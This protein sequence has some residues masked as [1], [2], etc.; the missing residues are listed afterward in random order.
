M[1]LFVLQ[2]EDIWRD[3]TNEDYMCL[4]PEQQY[5]Q[6]KSHQAEESNDLLQPVNLNSNP[7]SWFKAKV[8]VV[9]ASVSQNEHI[10]HDPTN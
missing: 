10:S 5:S 1:Y 3:P 7:L 4:A 8:F 6:T 2:I 9:Y